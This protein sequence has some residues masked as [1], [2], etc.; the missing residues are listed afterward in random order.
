MWARA[1]VRWGLSWVAL[2]V[3]WS[4]LYGILFVALGRPPVAAPM[5]MFMYH[6]TYAPLF[7]GLVAAMAAT[8]VPWLA[9][10]LPSPTDDTTSGPARWLRLGGALVIAALASSVPCGVLYILLDMHE[11]FVPPDG[12]A[13][14]HMRWGIGEACLV[15]P[16]VLALS[17]PL[18]IA[19]VASGIAIFQRIDDGRLSASPREPSP[20]KG[21]SPE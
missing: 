8:L 14:A 7:L 4:V 5:R 2:T 17:F 6:H 21:R 9:S 15:G 10:R 12:I 19:C 11:G 3:T 20:R 16:W 13:G 18:N 1:L